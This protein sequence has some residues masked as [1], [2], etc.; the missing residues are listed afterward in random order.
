[1]CNED[2][3]F[4]YGIDETTETVHCSN[5]KNL[6]TLPELPSSVRELKVSNT[7]ITSLPELPSGL[8]FLDISDTQ[9]T[10][11]PKLP[12]GLVTLRMDDLPLEN[13]PVIP[14]SVT[15][16]R[17]SLLPN[18]KRHPRMDELVKKYN[19]DKDVAAFKQ[20]IVDE[21]RNIAE[22]RKASYIKTLTRGPDF[23]PG[24]LTT[25][26]TGLPYGEAAKRTDDVKAEVKRRMTGTGRKTRR[27]GVISQDQTGTP[28]Q[29][30]EEVSTKLFDN[31]TGKLQDEYISVVEAAILKK[32]WVSG[33]HTPGPTKVTYHKDGN[34]FVVK[35]PFARMI[36]TIRGTEGELYAGQPKGTVVFPDIIT[37]V[38]D[39]LAE[40]ANPPIP[41]G[42]TRR[43]NMRKK[44][45]MKR[46]ARRT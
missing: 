3:Y 11:L 26:A 46:K 43:R 37:S 1:M 14:N 45:T 13:I 19:K 27:G 29:I 15:S 44:R 2:G 21:K 28:I 42:G 35:F 33:K 8:Q 9:I 31:Q 39:G 4:P 38:V 30:P 20:A 36:V 12:D 18:P 32:I 34:A 40:V 5:N 17:I 16:I 7:S 23:L 41:K 6:E 22:A 10:S 24:L 25:Y